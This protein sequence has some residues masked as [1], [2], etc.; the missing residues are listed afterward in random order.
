MSCKCCYKPDLNQ[1]FMDEFFV[2]RKYALSGKVLW[3]RDL[4]KVF[5]QAWSRNN[6]R[7]WIFMNDNT[8]SGKLYCLD[9]VTGEI[10][11]ESADLTGIGGSY[12]M[13]SFNRLWSFSDN[14][15]LVGSSLLASPE[16]PYYIMYSAD[17]TILWQ[18]NPSTEGP[19]KSN[20]GILTVLPDGNILANGH[21]DATPITYSGIQT[22]YDGATGALIGPFDSY[23][24]LATSGDLTEFRNYASKDVGGFFGNSNNVCC[25]GSVLINSSNSAHDVNFVVPVGNDGELSI[26][27]FFTINVDVD[28]TTETL[29]ASQSDGN[30][31]QVTAC[32]AGDSVISSPTNRTYDWYSYLLDTD[33]TNDS[34]GRSGPWSRANLVR[35]S[36][37]WEPSLSIGGFDYSDDL[38]A[39]EDVSFS[40]VDGDEDDITNAIFGHDNEHWVVRSGPSDDLEEECLSVSANTMSLQGR[41]RQPDGSYIHSSKQGTLDSTKYIQTA[42][43]GGSVIMSE[44]TTGQSLPAFDWVVEEYLDVDIWEAQNNH[45]WLN[46]QVFQQSIVTPNGVM[47][48][49][50]NFN[51][52]N[53]SDPPGAKLA[54]GIWTF[55]NST[56]DAVVYM[57]VSATSISS[58]GSFS[59]PGTGRG[60]I[61]DDTLIFRFSTTIYLATSSGTV[62]AVTLEAPIVSVDGTLAGSDTTFTAASWTVPVGIWTG[63]RAAI[64]LSSSGNFIGCVD[65]TGDLLWASKWGTVTNA[66][67]VS[68]QY[69]SDGTLIVLGNRASDESLPL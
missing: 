16:S 29:H 25:V 41:W 6:D 33:K 4:E 34:S 53:A 22:I 40:L 7:I 66:A 11:W 30:A 37:T 9:N 54:V 68:A 19:P 47:W 63:N 28:V 39:P 31:N 24:E 35:G 48:Q 51:V 45:V 5:P 15:V 38:S 10:I 69:N 58:A 50:Y 55:G 12:Q 21:T 14:R 2:V 57:D 42:D 43:C 52:D 36:R 61:D 3:Q 1:I 32:G 18:K 67:T 49:R 17:G 27:G 46:C 65:L 13:S 20:G 64:P 60:L 8:S 56:V 23:N 26:A 62:T 59:S 44:R